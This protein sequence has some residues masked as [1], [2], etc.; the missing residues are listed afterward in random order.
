[1]ILFLN[2]EIDQPKTPPDEYLS[3]NSLNKDYT[4]DSDDESIVAESYE[5]GSEI[6]FTDKSDEEDIL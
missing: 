4:D 3:P 2:Y 6:K 1:M 5:E